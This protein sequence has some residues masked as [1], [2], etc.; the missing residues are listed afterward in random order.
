MRTL[1]ALTF[2]LA[3]AAYAAGPTSAH[4][5]GPPE[6]SRIVRDLPY[7]DRDPAQNRLDVYVP[8]AGNQGGAALP[9]VVWVHGGGW[10]TGSKDNLPG[11]RIKLFTDLPAVLVS[12]DYRLSPAP[13]D[14]SAPGAVR[15]P[16]HARDVAD[17][18]RWIHD[19]IGDYGGDPNRIALVGFS[20]GAHLVSLVATQPDL[21]GPVRTEAISCV[22]ALDTEG[23]D[24]PTHLAQDWDVDNLE[25]FWNAFGLDPAAWAAASPITWLSPDREVAPFLVGTRGQAARIAI[26][27]AFAARVREVG[28]RAQVVDLNPY[29]HGEVG[30]MLGAPGERKVSDPV[31]AFLTDCL[32]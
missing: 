7:A 13:A 29:E 19:H 20:A 30:R 15:H 18:V 26:A 12:V 31:R 2:A 24:L 11:G 3:T 32:R 25:L 6:G 9:V 5:G 14:P 23:L 21:L 4:A 10:A 8:P 27:D 17:A 16:D 1:L 22:V 28:G